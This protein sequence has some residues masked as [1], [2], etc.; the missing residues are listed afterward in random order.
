MRNVSCLTACKAEFGRRSSD[1][2]LILAPVDPLPATANPPG[3]GDYTKVPYTCSAVAC[4]PHALEYAIS[5]T[6][7]L[8]HVIGAL[9]CDYS[10]PLLW[11]RG[12][13]SARAQQTSLGDDQE[14][15]LS[16]RTPEQIGNGVHESPTFPAVR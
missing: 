16:A 6:L 11:N 10:C 12:S 4:V 14:R 9:P 8:V 2:Q 7:L 1:A 5:I 3:V 15:L 13:A